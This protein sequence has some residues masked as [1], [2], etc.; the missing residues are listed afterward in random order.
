V[1]LSDEGLDGVNVHVLNDGPA[2]LK[3]EVEVQLLHAGR[4]AAATRASIE[5]PAHSG[6]TLQSD[7]LFGYFTD[8]NH[9]YRFGPAKYEVIVARLID[10]EGHVLAEDFLFPCGMSL[11]RERG[12][13]IEAKVSRNED[14]R[15]QVTLAS[16]VFLQDV[17]IEAA[18]FRASDSHFHLSPSLHRRIDF[19]PEADAPPIFEGTI[20][21]LNLAETVVIRQP[22]QQEQGEE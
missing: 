19:Y 9:A 5:I 4:V 2:P 6:R 8:C 13:R 14:G 22:G 20:E 18:G 11:P 21:A 1:R 17:R 10:A 12:A 16:D 7:A 15:V 3:G